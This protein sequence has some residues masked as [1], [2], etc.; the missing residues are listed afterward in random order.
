MKFNFDEIIER[1]NTNSVKYSME[2]FG[3]Q[4]ELIPLWVADMDFK[5]APCI[6]D[7]VQKRNDHGIFGYSVADDKYKE[8][9]S[10]WFATRH[11]WNIE[12]D[13]L[14]LA[15]GVVTAIYTAVRAFTNPGDAVIIN[16]P[17]YGPF[18]SSVEQSGRKLVVCEL[19]YDNGIYTIDYNDFEEK[20]KQENVK[21]FILCNPHNPVGRVWTEEELDNLGK[22]CV[23][24]GV[25]V[26]SDEIH[27]D[28]IY[29]G[30]KH[31]VFANINPDFADITITCTAPTKTFNIAGLSISNI[32]IANK[33]L[34][35][36]FT[37]EYSKA[38][39]SPI[40]IMGITAC[41]AAYSDGSD[42][43]DQL[44]KYLA[45]NIAYIDS[46]LKDRIPSVKCVD[47]EGTFLVWLDFKELGL[48]DDKLDELISNKAR[49]WLN[50]GVS[51]GAGG[52][53]FMR[54]NA[55]CTRSTLE[56]AMERLETAILR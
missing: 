43:L 56:I 22:I 13:W 42:W 47:T 24:H 33:E 16:Q 39:L 10:R 3:K 41:Q 5:T 44:K 20:V 26:V 11:D 54:L 48:S 30:H 4:P 45:G 36:T 31:F 51:F 49:L 32:F 14:V 1:R 25:L 52:S 17:V 46:F 8:T 29:D 35:E 34:R 38:G 28:F 55:G 19:T 2:A 15:P 7:A 6:I 37:R 53:G 18:V 23:K 21:M 50:I 27:Q 12:N 40:G 9:L